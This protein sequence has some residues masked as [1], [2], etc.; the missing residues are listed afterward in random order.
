MAVVPIDNYSPIF[1]SD[2]A[3]PFIIRVLKQYTN[4]PESILD[5]DISMHMQNVDDP[6]D[7][8]VCNGEWT[9]DSSDNGVASY[10]YEDEDVNVVGSWYMWVKVVLNSRIVHPDDGQGNAKILVIKELPEGV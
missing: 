8:K 5:A 10:Q 7:I 3:N 1:R 6:E 4:E 2:T 9:K